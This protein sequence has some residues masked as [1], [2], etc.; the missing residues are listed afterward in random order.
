MLLEIQT[1]PG[2]L[3]VFKS[4]L[5]EYFGCSKK[6]LP[7]CFAGCRQTKQNKTINWQKHKF[8]ALP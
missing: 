3:N 5:K 7:L 1:Q 4:G 2:W 8:S 6:I